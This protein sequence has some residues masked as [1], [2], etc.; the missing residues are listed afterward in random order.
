[1]SERFVDVGSVDNFI[2]EQVNKATLQKLLK[3]LRFRVNNTHFMK[4]WKDVEFL[5]NVWAN[6]THFIVL[7]L[8]I[9]IFVWKKSQYLWNKHIAAWKMLCTIFIHSLF[10]IRKLTRSLRSLVRF[11][12]LLNSW[13]KIVRAYFPWSYL[14]FR[15]KIA[16][17]YNYLYIVLWI[18][19]LVYYRCKWVRKENETLLHITSQMVLYGWQEAIAWNQSEKET[20]RGAARGCIVVEV[21]PNHAT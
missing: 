18:S 14:Y 11:L 3:F 13:I 15:G 21:G 9:V 12:I 16:E 7:S 19:F 1:M 6:K 5:K 8:L 10:R 20:P 17:F 2:E 4:F